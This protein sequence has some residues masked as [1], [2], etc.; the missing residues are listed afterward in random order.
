MDG[1]KE[2]PDT[3]AEGY[4]GPVLLMCLTG[5]YDSFW[6]GLSCKGIFKGIEMDD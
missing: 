3:E 2:A 5:D 4:V 6:Y 1:C